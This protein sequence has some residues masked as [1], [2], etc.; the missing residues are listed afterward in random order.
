MIRTDATM[1]MQ[2]TRANNPHPTDIALPP[3]L[4]F[5]EA[6]RYVRQYIPDAGTP[7]CRIQVMQAK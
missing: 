5:W 3:G 4:T 6:V 1:Y 7:T 2:V